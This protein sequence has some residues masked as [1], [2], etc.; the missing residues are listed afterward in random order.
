VEAVVAGF[1]TAYAADNRYRTAHHGPAIVPPS[2][3]GAAAR[4]FALPL[5]APATGDRVVVFAQGGI[6][7]TAFRVNHDP[8]RPAVGYR[9]DYK[10]RAVVISGDTAKS[11]SLEAAAK[12]ADLLVHEALQ[13]RLVKAMTAA[14][15]AKG[16]ANTAAIT[17]DILTYHATPEQAAESATAAGVRQLVLSHIVPPI[18][19]RF[20]YPA[21][22]GDAASR[23]SGPIIVG[24]DGMIFS[25]PAGSTAIDRRDLL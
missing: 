21:F 6:T 14:L 7:V 22:L 13:P 16:Q 4:P 3:A 18:P 1:N 24:E 8:V 11:A 20:F 17:R 5:S 12:G 15:A 19:G 2:G 10:G 25:L 23:F 9:F